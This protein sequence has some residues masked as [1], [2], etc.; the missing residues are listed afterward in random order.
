[1]L[2][3]RPSRIEMLLSGFGDGELDG[4]FGDGKL[5]GAGEEA[6]AHGL[7]STSTS[8]AASAAAISPCPSIALCFCG[9]QTF[10]G[11]EGRGAAAAD[12]GTAAF[13]GKVFV[14]VVDG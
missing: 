11:I 13:R 9:G 8:I 10:L 4:A 1:M 5:D 3:L 6:P 14:A 12:C 2:F 7:S